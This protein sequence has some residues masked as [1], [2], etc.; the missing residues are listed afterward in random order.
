MTIYKETFKDD[1]TFTTVS[2]EGG[3][4]E[5]R[6]LIQE[7]WEEIPADKEKRLKLDINKE[8]YFALANDGK[9][10]AYFCYYK[11]KLVGYFVIFADLHINY[12]TH[13]FA[14]SDAFYLHPEHR[15]MGVGSA[16][17]LF[18]KNHL[19]TLGASV[20]SVTTTEHRPFDDLLLELGFRKQETS[21]MMVLLDEE[22]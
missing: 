13:I 6:E 18:V 7:H 16:F 20:F 1:Y 11:D 2:V 15:G 17:I 10:G 9:I 21:Y 22:E 12:R 8:Q 14:Q 19:K 3:F 4:D 5:V